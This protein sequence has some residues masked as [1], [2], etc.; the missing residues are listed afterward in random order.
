MRHLAER[1]TL[2]SI[3]RAVAHRHGERTPEDHADRARLERAALSLGDEHAVIR[4][5]RKGGD[6]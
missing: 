2:A 5:P 1:P 6:E 3:E 4:A